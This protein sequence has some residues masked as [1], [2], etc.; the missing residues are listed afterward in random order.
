MIVALYKK[1]VYEA[2]YVEMRKEVADAMK[3]FGDPE[4]NDRPQGIID[5]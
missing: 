5:A 4:S 3:Q 2:L 1:E